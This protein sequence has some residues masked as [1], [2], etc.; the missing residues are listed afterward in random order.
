MEFVFF[1]FPENGENGL[2]DHEGADGGNALL[3]NLWA[4]TDP[5]SLGHHAKADTHF[6]V[7]RRVEG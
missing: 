6:I 1:G 4:R 5:A 2:G 3:Q 7:P